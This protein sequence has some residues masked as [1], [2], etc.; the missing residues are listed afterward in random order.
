MGRFPDEDETGIADPFH[1][2]IEIGGRI[3][4]PGSGAQPRPV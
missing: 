2:R 4:G 1:D 3:E